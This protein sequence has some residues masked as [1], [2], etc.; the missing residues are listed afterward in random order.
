MRPI[1]L[2]AV[3]ATAMALASCI[4]RQDVL[5]TEPAYVEIGAGDHQDAALCIWRKFTAGGGGGDVRYATS[6]LESEIAAVAS[7]PTYS[8][9]VVIIQIKQLDEETYEVRAFGQTTLLG[10][11][12]AAISAE[13]WRDCVEPRVSL[14]PDE[15]SAP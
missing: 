15:S 14:V 4:T 2:L 11:N 1:T 3:V 8:A 7:T 12:V 13:G 5:S 9:P 10:N 6:P